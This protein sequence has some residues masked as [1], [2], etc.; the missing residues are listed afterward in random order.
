MSLVLTRFGRMVGRAIPSSSIRGWILRRYYRLVQGRQ[1]VKEW[2]GIRYALDLDEGI[3]VSVSLGIFEVAVQTALAE[4]CKPGM[5]VID[6]GANIGAH[7]LP[8]S[9]LVQ[10]HGIVYAFEPTQYAYDKLAKNVALNLGL[11]IKTFRVALSDHE[12]QDREIHFRSSWCTDGG[13]K[14][15]PCRVDFVRLDDWGLTNSIGG[16]ISLIKMD[17]DGNEFPIIAGG[18]NLIIR[19]R[20]VF[21][22]EAVGPHFD[23]DEANPFRWLWMHGWRFFTLDR[24]HR[25]SS[26]EEVG[27]LLPRNDPQMT[28]SINVLA[29]HEEKLR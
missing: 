1:V 23:H 26:V 8:M 6:I 12:E 17:V 22:M 11:P 27:S 16:P 13:R 24:K 19:D 5:R 18:A 4:Y 3:D 29:I 10:P 14:D 9:R 15:E 20:P 25:Y 2:G 28:K 21:V 7:A